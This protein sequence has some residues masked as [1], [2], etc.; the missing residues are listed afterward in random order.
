MISRYNMM[1]SRYHMMISRYNSMIFRYNIMITHS[2][3]Y[4]DFSVRF[5]VFSFYHLMI[6]RGTI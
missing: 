5:G 1:I 4:D 2:V 6:S 3:Q